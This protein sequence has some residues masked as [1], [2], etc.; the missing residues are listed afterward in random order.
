VL[1]TLLLFLAPAAAFSLTNILGG[2]GRDFA[3]SEPW[4]G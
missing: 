2:L 1:W 3:T 4:S